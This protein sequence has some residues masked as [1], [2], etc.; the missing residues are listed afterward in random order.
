VCLL[1]IEKEIPVNQQITPAGPKPSPAKM[2]SELSNTTTLMW[3]GVALLIHVVVFGATS[4]NY[5]RGALAGHSAEPPT[6]EAAPPAGSPA[7]APA[8]TPAPAPV[9]ASAVPPAT[10]AAASTPS[11]EAKPA[12]ASDEAKMLEAHKDSPEVKAITEAAK[13]SELP[14]GPSHN[15]ME[16][17]SL[18]GK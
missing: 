12:A 7:A 17:D 15:A 3:I 9:A 13:P 6:A 18:E 14:K 10:P 4:I 5:L 2:L 11:P 16:L 8:A 1:Q